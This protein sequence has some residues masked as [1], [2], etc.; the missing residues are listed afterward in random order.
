MKKLTVLILLVT[1]IA[2]GVNAQKLY[3]PYD[4]YSDMVDY[5][6][7]ASD[8]M[9]DDA[10]SRMFCKNDLYIY[11]DKKGFISIGDHDRVTIA[12]YDKKGNWHETQIYMLYCYTKRNKRKLKK[13]YQKIS[14][15]FEKVIL[16]KE[17]VLDEELYFTKIIN[18]KGT[19]YEMRATYEKT[20]DDSLIILDEEGE[21]VKLK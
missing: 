10:I 13:E 3:K 19:W 8:E 2:T 21:F 20:N 16:E 15:A 12:V 7:K 11:Q 4:A 17:F 5:E 6:Y 1:I 9:I 14:K 18:N